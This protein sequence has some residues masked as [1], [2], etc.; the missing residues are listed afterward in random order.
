MLLAPPLDSVALPPVPEP[1]RT[2]SEL[3]L[4]LTLTTATAGKTNSATNQVAE[5]DMVCSRDPGSSTRVLAGDTLPHTQ[6]TPFAAR[7]ERRELGSSAYFA[8]ASAWT[9][10]IASMR[11]KQASLRILCALA[12]G[13]VAC[14]EPSGPAR[15]ASPRST[16]VATSVAPRVAFESRA[17]ALAWS[18]SAQLPFDARR[19]NSDHTL[20]VRFMPAYEGGYRA[21]IVA[22]GSGRYR[23]GLAPYASLNQPAVEVSLASSTLTAPLPAPNLSS[24]DV[25]R[26]ASPAPPARWLTLA[27]SVRG[28]EAKVFL[29]G[30]SVGTLA[31]EGPRDFEGELR[32][33]R[34]PHPESIQ[35]QLY[36]F[37][38]DVAVFE[39]AL[40]EPELLAL[41]RTRRVEPKLAGLLA[42]ATFDA[43]DRESSELEAR[44]T[45]AAELQSVSRERDARADTARLPAPHSPQ[46]LTLPFEKGQVWMVIQGT[47]S[48]G[49]HHDTAAFALDFQ[50]VDPA[51]V[52][53]NP[54]HDP[55][56]SAARSE[57][58]AVRAVAAGTVVSRVACFREDG[59]SNCAGAKLDP[60]DGERAQ[61]NLVCVEHAPSFVS[62]YLHLK[63]AA[64]QIGARVE[65]G[66]L[67]GS[68]GHTGT[69][70][71]HL[72]FAVSD[73][74]EPNEP[75]TFADL[76]TIPVEFSAYDAS[77]DFGRHWVHIEV[78]TPR[79]GQWVRPGGVVP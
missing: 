56:N 18:G 7:N 68:V 10:T 33:G 38:D 75:G 53:H 49:S 23:V 21:V 67:L 63:T 46:R 71:A 13:L 16:T 12:C 50:R 73:R 51:L 78:G 15:R 40:S 31:L 66:E 14:R 60:I 55:G 59:S 52:E 47:N 8:H 42:V 69:A 9:R 48:V 20:F 54:R 11:Q 65:Q 57:N 19:L 1:D 70:F 6:H 41:A 2:G 43:G 44:L 22:D 64:K 26:G 77:D 61:R 34:L 76:T 25:S 58:Q 17:L 30:K 24:L 4:Q 37:I 45:G 79:V 35:D 29:E 27:V 32:L 3:V 74:A 5:L 39:R 28:S 62:C 72:H 36:G